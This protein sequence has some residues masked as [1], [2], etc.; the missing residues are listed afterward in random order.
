M[1]RQHA[2]EYGG[3]YTIYI[4]SSAHCIMN[5]VEQFKY[6]D[7]DKE[8]MK[9]L[10]VY[11]RSFRDVLLNLNLRGVYILSFIEVGGDSLQRLY[12]A[13]IYDQEFMIKRW[14]LSEPY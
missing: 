13:E 9:C 4:I 11:L 14:L 2:K 8:Q 5:D 6:I 10:L 3:G 12:E 7:V 1:T